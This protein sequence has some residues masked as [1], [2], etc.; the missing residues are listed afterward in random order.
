MSPRRA[1]GAALA[2]VTTV[3]AL[4]TLTAP[5]G[6]GP[7]TAAAS[8]PAE[9]AF[10]VVD[11]ELSWG[12]NDESNNKAHAPGTYNFLSAGAVP[13]PG[14]GG[15]SIVAPGVWQGTRTRAWRARSG[16]V[17]VQKQQPDG[18]FATAGFAGLSTGV[19]GA[20][21]TSTAGPFSQHRVVLGGGRGTVDP[22]AGTAR[23]QWRGSFSVVYYS[24]YSFF[25]VT[26]PSLEVAD[27]RARLRATLS[28]YAADRDDASQWTAVPPREVTLADLPGDLVLPAEGGFT[29][30]PAYRGVRWSP[31]AD[32]PRQ[33]RTG[34]SWG[35]FPASF[36]AYLDRVGTAAF[37]YSSG[38]TAD[39]HKV[40]RPLTVSYDAGRPV[41]P[42]PGSPGPSGPTAE[43]T[44]PTTPP[45]PTTSVNPEPPPTPPTPPTT[46]TPP[47]SPAATPSATPPTRPE[48][49]VVPPPSAAPDPTQ[50][51]GPPL[52]SQPPAS[53]PPATPPGVQDT[54]VA[55]PVPLAAA[56]VHAAGAVGTAGAAEPVAD[57]APQ[58]SPPTWPWWLGGAL[59]LAAALVT[60]HT[61]HAVHTARAARTRSRTTPSPRGN[62]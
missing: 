39:P 43:P 28:G 8:G 22:A 46:A 1:A 29:A 6:P 58:P 48:P 36:L 31:P 34:S 16:R 47:T 42:P 24:G 60:V 41:E 50:P 51:A 40:P 3:T 52:P 45:E 54:A 4:A 19:D 26:D 23:L 14:A 20:P 13:D 17:E 18:G 61:A 57:R 27:G 21:L 62:R 56:A 9:G 59:L 53:G 35:A 33:V 12:L 10:T 30:E 11:A 7:A 25:V 44:R 32:A 38:G 5:L 15:Q 2:A 55:A 49:P 37:W